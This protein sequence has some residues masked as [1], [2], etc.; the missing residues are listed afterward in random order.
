MRIALIASPIVLL[1]ACAEPVDRSR[2]TDSEAPPVAEVTETA[3]PTPVA[4]ATTGTIPPSFQ[5]KWGLVAADCTSTRGD[6]KG[7]IE[8]GESEIRFY[9]S[10]AKLGEVASQDE[11]SFR[12]TYAFTGEGMEWTRDIEW[13]IGDD[14][15][16]LR[17]SET[18]EDALAEPLTYTKCA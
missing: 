5:G 7:L 8:I 13:E 18:G 3:T 12:A 10:V 15:T 17:R 1:A 4:T 6:A 16:T 2:D 14:G 9:E 11:D